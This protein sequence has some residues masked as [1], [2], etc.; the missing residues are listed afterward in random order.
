MSETPEPI[1]PGE[2]RELRAV[3]RSQIKVLRAEVGQR[4]MELTAEVENRLAERYAA[5]DAR[6]DEFSRRARELTREANNKMEELLSEF[7][8][9]FSGGKWMGRPMFETPRVYRSTQDR[10]QLRKAMQA[11]I[12]AQAK[13]AMLDLDRREADL[14]RDLAV[15]GL[16]TSAARAF[17]GRIP[18]VAELVP[19]KRLREIE[20]AFDE[21]GEPKS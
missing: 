9:D 17:L 6:A 21:A 7:A 3:V 18:T 16:E 10:D 4:E 5:D 1:T 14:L 15:D 12:K 8:E 13:Q 20:S 2:R 19:S 11:G